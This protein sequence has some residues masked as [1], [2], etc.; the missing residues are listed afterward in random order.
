MGNPP[1]IGGKYKRDALGS[2]YFD[3]LGKCYTELPEACDFVMYWWHKAA[4]NVREGKA[5]RFG[6]ITTNSLGQVFNRRVTAFHLSADPPL[7]IAFAVPDHPWVDATDGADVRIAM[8]VGQAGGTEGTLAT[9]T[10]ELP[11]E[12]TELQVVLSEQLGRINA[13]LT[14]G[15]NVASAVT[16][17]ANEGLSCPG[18]K[19]HGAGFI[20]TPKEAVSLGL[21]RIPGLE[22]HIRPYRHGRDIADKPRGV[23]VIDL[24]GLSEDEVRDRLPRSLSV[25]VGTRKAGAGHQR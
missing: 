18:V 5:R 19:L 8:T 10:A 16:L 24:F 1:F 11:T 14:I 25:G 2:G 17:R 7:S 23:L 15:A 20:V 13:D 4:G 21:G 6:F 9:V 12:G 3:A 22:Q